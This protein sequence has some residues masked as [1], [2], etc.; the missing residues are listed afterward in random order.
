[1]TYLINLFISITF[2]FNDQV[3]GALLLSLDLGVVRWRR[4][5][6]PAFI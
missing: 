2:Q 4:L 1:M 5:A 3:I 6:L